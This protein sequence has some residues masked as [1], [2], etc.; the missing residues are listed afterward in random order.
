MSAS[1]VE[2]V[3]LPCVAPGA[4]R[5]RHRRHRQHGNP[6]SIRG[7]LTAPDWPAIYGREAPLA[8]DI[9]CGPGAFVVELARQHPGWNVLGLEIR[10]HFIDSVKSKAQ[11]LGLGNVHALLANANV[12]LAELLPDHS[13]TFLSLNFPDPWYKR[14]HHK[15]R[16]MRS[17]W[18]AALAPKLMAGA[19][20]HAMTDYEVLA[21]EIQGVLEG[22]PWLV[23]LDGAGCFATV[24]TSGVASERELTHVLRGE[25][26]YRLRFRRQPG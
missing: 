11:S 17:E 12:H 9:G 22:T 6:F 3:V 20:L 7:P 25:P 14:R 13:V 2:P 4:A 8:I 15:R 10:Q 1:Q 5:D 19:E 18:L 26:I 21:L 24:S 16:V 23:N